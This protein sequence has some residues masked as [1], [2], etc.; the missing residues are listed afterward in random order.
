DH[1]RHALAEN[2]LGPEHLCLELTE[3]I[4]M[5]DTARTAATLDVLHR[6]GVQLSIDDFG[7][8]YSSLAYL[9][10]FPVD[11]LKIDRSFINNIAEDG[12]QRSLVTA[13]IA[14]GKA[15]GLQIVAEG[16]EQQVQADLL[17][18]LGCHMAQGYLFARPQPADGLASV[19]RRTTAAPTSCS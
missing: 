1:I 8:G 15:L 18:E 16:V 7:T 2:D 12:Q 10:R 4:L 19:L 13:M 3:S 14:M 11:E 6:L 17:R 9:H 5:R